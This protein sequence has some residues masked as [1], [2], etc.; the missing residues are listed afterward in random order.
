MDDE[1]ADNNPEKQYYLR[2]QT[3]VESYHEE[4]ADNQ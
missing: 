1:L 2:V 4:E 3:E